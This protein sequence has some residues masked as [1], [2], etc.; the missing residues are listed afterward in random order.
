MYHS[1][2]TACVSR[3]CGESLDKREGAPLIPTRKMALIQRSAARVVRLL[4]SGGL[5][6]EKWRRVLPI[7]NRLVHTAGNT[8][9]F[10]LGSQIGMDEH[11]IRMISI[12]EEQIRISH[13]LLRDDRAIHK[14]LLSVQARAAIEQMDHLMAV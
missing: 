4:P 9:G 10:K 2:L 3:R 12:S 8:V 6:V 13:T 7:E 5:P 1:G 14:R 11:V